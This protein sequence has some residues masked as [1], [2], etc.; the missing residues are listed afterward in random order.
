MIAGRD[1]ATFGEAKN[2]WLTGTASWCFVAVSQWILGIY[3]EYDGLRIDPCL[4][5]HL[6]EYT[7]RRKFR[8][9]EYVIHV[10]NPD[11]AQKGVKS[12][13]ADGMTIKGNVVPISEKDKVLLEVVM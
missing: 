1:A 9:T 10:L 2:S 6:K 5:K 7:V 12:I 3:P 11:N 13:K 4:P 8:S